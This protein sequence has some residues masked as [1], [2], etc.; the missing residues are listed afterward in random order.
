[1]QYIFIADQPASPLE[2]QPAPLAVN[3]NEITLVNPKRW[4]A[5]LNPRWDQSSFDLH[6]GLDMNEGEIDTIPTE[7]LDALFKG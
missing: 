7:L 5:A 4:T 6:L 1:M 3:G 2:T